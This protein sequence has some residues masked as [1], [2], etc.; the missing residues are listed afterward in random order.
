MSVQTIDLNNLGSRW[1][2]IGTQPGPKYGFTDIQI[3]KAVQDQ[4]I[5]VY[6]VNP[7]EMREKVPNILHNVQPHVIY[8]EAINGWK[9]WDL[10]KDY[11]CKAK[12][13]TW[14]DDPIMRMDFSGIGKR[15]MDNNVNEFG[16]FNGLTDKVGHSTRQNVKIFCWDDYW[17]QRLFMDCGMICSKLLHLAAC[18][19]DYYSANVACTNKPIFIGSLHSPRGLNTIQE[20]L[21]EPFNTILNSIKEELY[22]MEDIPSWD[23]IEGHYL[24][25]LGDGERRLYQDICN[26]DRM[27]QSY[28]RQCIWGHSKNAVRVRMLRAALEVSPVIMFSET[29]QINHVKEGELRAMIGKN[30]HKL[31][32]HDTTGLPQEKLAMLNHWGWVHLQATDPQ[33]VYHGYPYRMFQTMASGKALLTDMKEYWSND[34]KHEEHLIA[35]KGDEILKSNLNFMLKDKDGC[36]QI[37]NAARELFLRKHTWQHR[38]HE[39]LNA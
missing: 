32:F 30:E 28:F 3:I 22:K 7:N 21:C 23:K 2:I 38:I 18:H 5:E 6:Y 24:G 33:S 16:D 17:N 1:L 37:G 25:I 9:I 11:K 19:K 8:W 27:M 31:E 14:F 35:Y 20:R 15:M 34:F 4:G 29:G 10:I 36:R 26:S 39:M 12:I 13:N